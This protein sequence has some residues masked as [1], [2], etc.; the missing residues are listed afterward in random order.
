MSFEFLNLPLRLEMPSAYIISFVNACKV[1]NNHFR[2]LTCPY[3]ATAPH[4]FDKQTLVLMAL[5]SITM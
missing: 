3:L 2:L 5:K 1:L 4:N